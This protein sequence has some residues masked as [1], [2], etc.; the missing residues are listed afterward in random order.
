MAL[1]MQSPRPP[2][3]PRPTP[4]K[5][6]LFVVN[7]VFQNWCQD[8]RENEKAL[9]LVPSRVGSPHSHKNRSTQQDHWNLPHRQPN[10]N[11]L[12]YHGYG[13]HEN[14]TGVSGE[15]LN[16]PNQQFQENINNTD[17]AES[18]K[19]G[20]SRTVILLIALSWLVSITALLLTVMVIF[21]KIGSPCGCSGT[22]VV[23]LVP[24]QVQQVN[25]NQNNELLAKMKF[26]EEN[27][28]NHHDALISKS[29]RLEQVENTLNALE[30]KHENIIKMIE[31][32]GFNMTTLLSTTS[33]MDY[34]L[35][36]LEKRT[37]RALDAIN[38][39]TARLKEEEITL[40][41]DLKKV[42]VTLSAKI[43][44]TTARL[45]EEEITLNSDLKKVNVTLSAKL[46]LLNSS[47][48]VV[49][50]LANETKRDFQTFKL[51]MENSL[52]TVFKSLQNLEEN[53]NLTK[54][55]LSLDIFNTKEMLQNATDRLD[56]EDANLKLLLS[57]INSTLFLKIENVSKLPGPVG[58]PGVNG[59]QGPIGPAG[60]QGFNGSQGAIGPQGF[61]GSQ[62]PIGPQGPQG[63]GDFSLCEYVSTSSRGSQNP[64]TSINPAASIQVT[65]G[66]PNDK[67]IVAVSCST[68]RAQ[69]YLLSSLINPSNGQRFYYCDCFGHFDAG[70]QSVTCFMS[71]WLCPLST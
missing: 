12:H 68:D 71:Y 66:E 24:P 6:N 70:S 22:Q 62:G 69:M 15:S 65:L 29:S 23:L 39:T 58:P 16:L 52:S 48:S 5:T 38:R 60:P 45:K 19:Y 3:P 8:G 51:S 18:K 21:D 41:S 10:S 1:L 63:A 7:P 34:K 32:I 30:R 43:N 37:N 11:K 40:N 28:S 59:S 56:R 46:T 64:V 49:T 67:R 55:S 25:S 50:A 2:R 17:F 33:Y 42:N 31:R 36:D 26:L 27:V 20:P 61:N 47:L 53:G 54:D 13:I 4:G 35:T 44:R 57:E 14:N 9:G